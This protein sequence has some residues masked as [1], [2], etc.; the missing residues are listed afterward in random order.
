MNA[1]RGWVI[2]RSTD[3]IPCVL[4][5]SGK[6]AD[7]ALTHERIGVIA[8]VN[9]SFH[10]SIASIWYFKTISID[11]EC[12]TRY[13]AWEYA[14]NLG[15]FS[16]GSDGKNVHKKMKKHRQGWDRHCRACWHIVL[17]QYRWITISSTCLELNCLS[18]YL[19]IGRVEFQVGLPA[20]PNVPIYVIDPS[21]YIDFGERKSRW[22]ECTYRTNDKPQPIPASHPPFLT[23][24]FWPLLSDDEILDLIKEFVSRF[25]NEDLQ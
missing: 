11:I 25:I 16:A 1:N 21:W 19:R 12:Y 15:D 24:V 3:L 17:H 7:I 9:V 8:L 2:T 23:V 4:L 6:G 5:E 18:I 14:H 13:Q 10:P 20:P 22:F